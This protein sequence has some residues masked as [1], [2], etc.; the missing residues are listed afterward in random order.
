MP[1]YRTVDSSLWTPVHRLETTSMY[2]HVAT[3]VLREVISPL[4]VLPTP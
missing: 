3:E 2:T 1:R 4:E